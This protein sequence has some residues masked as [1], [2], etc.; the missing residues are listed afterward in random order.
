MNTEFWLSAVQVEGQVK[1]KVAASDGP[2]LCPGLHKSDDQ[3]PANR[4]NWPIWVRNSFFAACRKVVP[5]LN[6]E[7]GR[8]SAIGTRYVLVMA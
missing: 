7:Q 4:K 8:D 2:I 6:D 3:L 1:Q 5:R